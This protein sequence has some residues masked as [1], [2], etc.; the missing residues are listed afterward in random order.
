MVK[1]ENVQ[2][3]IDYMKEHKETY[4]QS[5]FFFEEPPDCKTP[6]C[7]CGFGVFAFGIDLPKGRVGYPLGVREMQRIQEEV[8][9]NLGINKYQRSSLFISNPY[10]AAGDFPHLPTFDE[11]IATLE[12]LRDKGK[13]E[14]PERRPLTR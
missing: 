5:K 10:H 12:T 14:W 8:A 3:L 1:K 2:I 13:V 11:A 6:G 4:N 7:I 9:N